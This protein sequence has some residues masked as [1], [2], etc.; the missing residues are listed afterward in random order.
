MGLL[1]VCCLLLLL[2]NG[3]AASTETKITVS[4]LLRELATKIE[5]GYLDIRGDGFKTIFA[6][7]FFQDRFNDVLLRNNYD[8][9]SRWSTIYPV[10]SVEEKLA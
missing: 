1:F 6:S 3:R 2:S 7:E 4:K 8:W 9:K 5:N 10:A